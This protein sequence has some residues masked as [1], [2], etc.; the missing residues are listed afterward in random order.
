[1][2]QVE[3]ELEFPD[4]IGACDMG[5]FGTSRKEKEEQ[6][7]L[8]RGR[9]KAKAESEQRIE[10]EMAASKLQAQ[11]EARFKTEWGAWLK[12]LDR[13][14]KESNEAQLSPEILDTIGDIP[15]PNAD[16]LTTIARANY[17]GF[18]RTY[19]KTLLLSITSSVTGADDH[20][21]TFWESVQVY[22]DENLYS[23]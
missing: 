15:K 19:T 3:P 14:Q 1:L 16:G 5:L 4:Q 6:A 20:R 10:T 22:V 11:D 2:G 17:R 9:A 8:E 18:I 21:R 7:E 13:V 12:N 23:L